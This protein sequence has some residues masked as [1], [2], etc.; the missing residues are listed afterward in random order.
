MAKERGMVGGRLEVSTGVYMAMIPYCYSA[1]PI[2]LL[3]GVLFLF[4]IFAFLIVLPCESQRTVT[5]E[6]STDRTIRSLSVQEFPLFRCS[7][8]LD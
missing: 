5:C 3:N 6:N 7:E 8:H 1:V 2:L 4:E